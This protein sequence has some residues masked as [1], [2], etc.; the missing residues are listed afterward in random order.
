MNAFS[1]RGLTFTNS[2][3]TELMSILSCHGCRAIP[4]PSTLVQLLVQ[5][6]RYTF[7]IQPAVV[8]HIMNGGIPSKHLPFW[9]CMTVDNLYSIYSSL[10]VSKAKVLNLLK[11]PN[12]LSVPEDEVYQYLKRLLATCLVMNS[13]LFYVL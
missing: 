10:S 8:L 3:K 1:L 7:L 12:F 5:A 9:K 13:V 6:S 4:P 11:E 2:V